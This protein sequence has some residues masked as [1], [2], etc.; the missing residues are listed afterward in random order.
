MDTRRRSV[1]ADRAAGA[2]D[3]AVRAVVDSWPDLMP[4]AL[5]W[6]QASHTRA[7]AAV[8]AC[9][10]GIVGVLAQGDLDDR[11]WARTHR[12][13]FAD[14]HATLDEAAELVR[15]VRVT[16]VDVLMRRLEADCGLSADERW[17]LQGEIG[18]FCEQLVGQEDDVEPGAV[19][20]LLATLEADGADFA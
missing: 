3:E 7:R 16:G 18:G 2:V 9:L 14:G 5:G 15:T 1:L 19:D 4:V 13:V 12:L 17:I 20:A 10:D 6:S 8:R 11:T